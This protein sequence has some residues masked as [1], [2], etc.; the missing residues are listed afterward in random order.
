[1]YLIT[2][3]NSDFGK[4]IFEMKMKFEAAGEYQRELSKK[5]RFTQWKRQGFDAL[6]R[7]STVMFE[8]ENLIDTK[9]WTLVKGTTNQYKPNLRIKLG[10]E[11]E[12]ELADKKG[13]VPRFEWIKAC[14]LN[15]IMKMPGYAFNDVYGGIVI[16]DDWGYE[17]PNGV[18][19]VTV[20]EFRKMFEI[21]QTN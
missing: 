14:G 18:K 3:Y 12:N 9:A 13:F 2:E 8:G 21:F 1:M 7:I 19:E 4:K 5:Y 16:H 11:I 15:D 6:G 10:K 17:I 20:T